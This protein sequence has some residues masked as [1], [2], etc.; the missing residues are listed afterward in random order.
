M[1]F[2][3]ITKNNLVRG[4]AALVVACAG[5]TLSLRLDA[6]QPPQSFS[7]GCSICNAWLHHKEFE[8]S[9]CHKANKSSDAGHTKI[10]D[11]SAFML[12]GYSGGV[13]F[14]D[15]YYV[16]QPYIS[17]NDPDPN[18]QCSSRSGSD[19]ACSQC[20]RFWNAAYGCVVGYSEDTRAPNTTAF[21]LPKFDS[22]GHSKNPQTSA[23]FFDGSG[24]NW[25]ISIETC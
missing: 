11:E 23:M 17:G 24:S 13:K 21:L 12:I 1:S 16:Y 7:Y 6:Q 25:S 22:N 2:S 15:P 14:F 10:D 8:G 4:S 19:Q 18:Y 3:I 9:T 20:S 5:T